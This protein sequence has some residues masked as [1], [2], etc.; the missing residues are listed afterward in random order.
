MVALRG[1]P[2]GL[3]RHAVAEVDHFR[4]EDA[5]LDKFEI[6]PALVPGEEGGATAD[7]HRVD[8]NGLAFSLNGRDRANEVRFGV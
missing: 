7:E 3:A 8:P 5:R 4:T 2:A 1:G 6:H